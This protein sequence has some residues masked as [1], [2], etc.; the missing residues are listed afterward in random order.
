MKIVSRNWDESG[1]SNTSSVW[2]SCAR[3]SHIIS[4]G[5]QWWRPE[6]SAV[7]FGLRVILI[8][9][10]SNMSRMKRIRWLTNVMWSYRGWR[11][12]V[13]SYLRIW[14]MKERPMTRSGQYHGNPLHK[15]HSWGR[16]GGG[17]TTQSLILVISSPRSNPS[18]FYTPFLTEKGTPFV[19]LPLTN[20]TPF[21]HLFWVYATGGQSWSQEDGKT[22]VLDKRERAIASVFCRELHLTSL[23]SGFFQT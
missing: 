20:G 10:F 2:N 6:M 19:H 7:F 11:K 21:M 16:G 22:L 13:K 5:N 14:R 17:G 12:K 4:L 9:F 18:P 1:C 8:F 15:Y 3:F 23:C